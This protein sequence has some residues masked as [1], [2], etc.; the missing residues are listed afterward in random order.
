VLLGRR[1]E[2]LKEAV[3]F[4]ARFVPTGSRDTASRTWP[5]RAVALATVTAML[6]LGA[7]ADVAD[8]RQ[9]WTARRGQL[10]STLDGIWRA[11]TRTR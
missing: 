9:A 5:G 8:V 6:A 3:V 1:G 7:C 10:A 2:Y 11:A 4:K